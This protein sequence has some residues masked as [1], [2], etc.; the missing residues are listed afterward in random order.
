MSLLLNKK[1]N[2]E[3]QLRIITNL[4]YFLKFHT[5]LKLNIVK[6]ILNCVLVS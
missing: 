5:F 6:Q 2:K 1:E 3:I 4:V